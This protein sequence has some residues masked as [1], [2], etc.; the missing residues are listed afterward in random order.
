MVSFLSFSR[1]R[2]ELPIVLSMDEA[3][4]I[5]AAIREPRYRIFFALLFDT[6]L[7]ISEG[8]D[9][10]VG[11]IDRGCGVILNAYKFP[12]P[13]GVPPGGPGNLAGNGGIKG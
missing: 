7:R 3:F 9:L 5:L 13:M 11:D 1:P 4:R 10:K 8:A 12:S 2:R 6:G